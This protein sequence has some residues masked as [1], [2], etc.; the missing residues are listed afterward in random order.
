MWLNS[1]EDVKTAVANYRN[2][3]ALG[4]SRLLPELFKAAKL[5]FDFGPANRRGAAGKGDQRASYGL[6][7]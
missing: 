6:E 3:L 4:G 2:A 7:Q 5:K 1:A